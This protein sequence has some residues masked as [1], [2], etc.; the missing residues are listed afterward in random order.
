MKRCR[1]ALSTIFVLRRSCK[2]L[3]VIRAAQGLTFGNRETVEFTMG[4]E[5]WKAWEMAL[6]RHAAIVDYEDRSVTNALD[7]VAFDICQAEHT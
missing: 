2:L 7:M 6:L 3:F 1:A 5:E 4:D